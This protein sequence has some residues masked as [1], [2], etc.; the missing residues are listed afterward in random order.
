MRTQRRLAANLLKCGENRIWI[1]PTHRQEVEK[2]ITR[3]DV[4]SL[5]S[6]GLIKKKQIKGVS[7]VRARE[8]AAK[9]KKGQRKG[10]GSRKGKKTARLPK[11]QAW[12]IKIRA[13]RRL[14][15][16]MKDT[17]DI[18]RSTYRKFYMLAKGGFFRSKAH[19][20]LYLKGKQE[21]GEL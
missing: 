10:H 13:Q 16:T 2:A 19:L 18:A 21:R 6:K 8:I 1:S 7:R 4:R 9:K 17:G 3:E 12:M 15:R 11:K 14:L 20:M 5:I